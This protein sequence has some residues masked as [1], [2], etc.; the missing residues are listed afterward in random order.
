MEIEIGVTTDNVI[1]RG[2]R[3]NLVEDVLIATL[4]NGVPD[5]IEEPLVCL[6]IGDRTGGHSVFFQTEILGCVG[7][8]RQGALAVRTRLLAV[9][10]EQVINTP[11]DLSRRNPLLLWLFGSDRKHERHAILH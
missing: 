10:L 6:E 4:L 8:L 1:D 7:T 2:A 9:T 11:L 3:P 5:I